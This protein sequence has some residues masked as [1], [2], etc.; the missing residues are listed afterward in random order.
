MFAH[1]Q[2]GEKEDP[3]LKARLRQCENRLR[4]LAEMPRIILWEMDLLTWRFT[5]VGPQA[6][7]ILGYPTEDWFEPDFW[8]KHLHP[9]DRGKAVQYCQECT[10]RLE[11]HEFQY[12]MIA[13]DGSIVWIDDIVT[14]VHDGKTPSM[15]SGVMIDITEQQEAHRALVEHETLLKHTLSSVAG[16]VVIANADGAIH[17][18]NPA[19][20][21]IFGY[22]ADE[23]TGKNLNI[24]MPANE[25]GRHDVYIARF[26]SSGVG[27]VMG[28]GRDLV[29]IRKS[30]EKFIIEITVCDF[31]SSGEKMFVATIRDLTESRR[32]ENLDQRL[33]RIL[34]ATPNGI[35]VIDADTGGIVQASQ[36]A[37]DNLQFSK[38]ELLAMTLPEILPDWSERDISDRVSRLIE[39][40]EQATVF[41]AHMLR[42]D[43]TRYEAELTVHYSG[44]EQPPVFVVFA[45]DL[46]DEIRAR[47]QKQ[48]L[49]AW[50]QKVQRLH[51]VG[52]LAS[53]I[54][55]D[56]NNILT[57]I[58]GYSAVLCEDLPKESE[59]FEDAVQIERAA[60]RGKSLI[61]QILAFGRPP[62]E[63]PQSVQLN[64][65]VDE[66]VLLLRPSL[67][68]NIEINWQPGAVEHVI[69]ANSGQIHQVLLNLC[70]NAIQAMHQTGG[71]IEI[72]LA[73]ADGGELPQALISG[74]GYKRY[75]MLSIKDT[76]PG[77]EPATMEHLF[78]PFFTT[79]EVGKGTGLGLS[80]AHGIVQAHGGAIEVANREGE[81]AE[82]RVYLPAAGQ[83][84]TN[85][86]SSPS[87]AASN[88]IKV[89]VI[90]DDAL[91]GALVCRMLQKAGDI[92]VATTDP[93]DAVMRISKNPDEF[94][95]IITDQIMPEKNGLDLAAEIRKLQP[96]IPIILLTG[97]EI[98]SSANGGI[99]DDVS[100]CLT[101]PINLQTL[102]EAVRKVTATASYQE[103]SKWP[104]Y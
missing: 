74:S 70:N 25:G 65:I 71:K 62:N 51:A 36:G 82:F 63:N 43:G 11:D 72:A 29:G 102:T 104:A 85:T 2:A 38:S 13:A 80:V 7:K 8:T 97:N 28:V 34:E 9:D 90:D 40:E 4:V 99:G 21:E 96:K 92:A 6:E 3:D 64:A 78:E 84:E 101:K 86:Q 19:A 42:G 87:L 31:E 81:G 50:L 83:D 17:S 44:A 76:G 88:A 10:E 22:T 46:T 30:G 73:E 24:L 54:A 68:T 79:K 32:A 35:L 66:V 91:L 5:Y 69:A 15:L 26:N 48:Q 93:E 67:P 59:S 12:R 95:L 94:D 27:K 57:P 45:K 41:T 103:Q 75:L 56:F 61:E 89:L 33:G 100:L 60:R 77:I 16:G 52:Q 1:P 23:I 98:L 49:D 47:Q 53:G 37:R 18:L 20:L 55:H 39:G 14:I 58:L